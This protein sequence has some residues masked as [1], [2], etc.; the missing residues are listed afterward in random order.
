MRAIDLCEPVAVRLIRDTYRRIGQ[1]E[2][3]AVR[4]VRENMQMLRDID[5][6]GQEQSDTEQQQGWRELAGSFLV[7]E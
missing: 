1:A 6:A 5:A 3:P 7:A 4:V 2:N